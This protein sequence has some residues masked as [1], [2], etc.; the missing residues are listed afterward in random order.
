MAVMHRS[1]RLAA[2]AAALL[3]PVALAGAQ[4]QVG[5]SDSIYTWRGALPAH[6]QLTIRNF[7]GPIDVRP[8]AGNTAEFRGVK[9]T[10]GS[11]SIQDIGFAVENGSNGDVSIC[12]SLRQSNPC[13]RDGYRGD[14][15]RGGHWR[16]DL[17]VAM[18]VLLPRGAQLKLTTGNG[19]VS[20]ENVGG[21]VQASTGNGRVR[22]A[23]TEGTVRVSTGNGDVDVRGAKS[24]VRV[25]TGNGRVNVVTADGPVEVHTGNGDI[26][27]VMSALK[28]KDDMTFSSG[29]G[30]VRVTL[31]AGYNGEL[32][33]STGNGELR[34]DFDL[35]IQGR[36]DPRHVRATIGDGGPR[37]RLS[38][39]NGRLAILKG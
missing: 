7:N 23:G 22:I 35:K 24:S 15:D 13:D 16:N 36:M 9:R 14:D 17:S 31:P 19:E 10:R 26:D 33:A 20:V 34:S 3:S 12:A 27:V 2:L 8:A 38:T 30:S 11:G 6:A 4:T 25:S 5:R 18:T 32:D 28:A 29:S 1:L 39:G 37:L 21:D